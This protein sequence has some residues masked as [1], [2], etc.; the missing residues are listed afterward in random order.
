M[1]TFNSLFFVVVFSSLLSFS[2]SSVVFAVP[3]QSDLFVQSISGF[4]AL[5]KSME[6]GGSFTIM[7]IVKNKGKKKADI[8][9]STQY[10]FSSDK[11]YSSDDILLTGSRTV[12]AL[13]SQKTSIG[14]TN[15]T[16]PSTTPTGTY[17]LIACVDDKK[18]ITESNENNNCKAT[19]KTINVT[20]A[21]FKVTMPASTDVKNVQVTAGDNTIKFLY[22]LPAGADKYDNI[23][24]DLQ[25]ILTNSVSIAGLTTGSNIKQLLA[26]LI[27]SAE[28][29][30]TVYVSA[31]IG[32]SIDT[33]CE[34]GFLYPFTISG[35]A[36][37]PTIDPPTATAAPSSVSIIKS[38]AFAICLQFNS[39]IDATVNANDVSV[40]VTPCN[41]A[42][43]NISGKWK[44]TYTCI[45]YGWPSDI[46]QPITLTITQNGSS[47]Q[48]VDDGGA[49]YQGT[50][51]GNVFK[52]NRVSPLDYDNENGTFVLNNNGTGTKNSTWF[53]NSSPSTNWGTCTDNLH[54]VKK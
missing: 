3:P 42:P 15:L 8:I 53:S 1:K 18:D 16:V 33:V 20:N 32:A 26:M 47:A 35:S 40:D 29:Q 5:P 7:T 52:F 43:K 9:F 41:Q 11:V 48:Y 2:I 36:L 25:D 44:G 45:N 23:S 31:R 4:P 28:A 49:V 46:N 34:D 27:S 14:K 6:S 51:C 37:N 39:P 10:Y 12:P 24:V 30:S 22:T 21:G 17:H 13:K 19:K 54:R 38:G 50:V